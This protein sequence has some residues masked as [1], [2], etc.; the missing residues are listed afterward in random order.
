MLW[1][2]IFKN[3]PGRHNLNDVFHMHAGA[4][5]QGDKRQKRMGVRKPEDHVC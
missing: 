4:E 2:F 3:A 5:L 1:S